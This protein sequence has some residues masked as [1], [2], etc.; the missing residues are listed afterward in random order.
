MH[1]V[2]EFT[3][4][5][6]FHVLALIEQLTTA[7]ASVANRSLSH[8]EFIVAAIVA[9]AVSVCLICFFWAMSE[10]TRRLSQRD[11]VRAASDRAQADILL[12]EAMIS[13]CPESIA[14]L[15]GARETSLSYR[16]GAV[17]LRACLAGPD[18]AML[19]A[20][21]EALVAT[22]AAFELRLRTASLPAVT[23]RGCPV[24]TRAAVFFRVEKDV[25]ETEADFCA[26]LDALPTPVW[27]RNRHLA[28]T[29]ANRAFLS[30][31]GASTMRDAQVTDTGLDRSE[32]DLARAASEGAEIV[33]TRRYAVID[34]RR[35]T[36][37]IDM[38]RL[39]DGGVA[40]F[41][42]DVTELATAEAKLHLHADAFGN[43][44]N[45]FETAIA[46]FGA[47]RRLAIYNAAYARMWRLPEQWLDTHPTL[48]DILDRLRETRRLPE[49]RDF[50][51]WKREHTAQFEKSAACVDETWHLPTGT[52]VEVRSFPYLLGGAIYLFRDISE[53]LRMEAS[54]HMLLRTQ[55]T[56]LNTISDAVA[57][58]GPD[59]RLK[60]HNNAFARF[61]KLD[62]GE[63]YG[64]PH[65]SKVADLCAARTG[66][67]G[68]WNIV[69]AG[70][71]STEPDRHGD[72]SRV[73]RAD[74]RTLTLTLNKLPEGATLVTFI[75]VTDLERFQTILLEE[76]EHSSVA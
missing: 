28:L 48:G 2:F 47:D 36:L 8:D 7:L 38:R 75:D 1:A 64:E 73:N 60:L 4:G 10:R 55:R 45:S 54:H 37:E 18:S 40:G 22:G 5:V 34:G 67:D 46:I 65:L 68:V 69:S 6:F 31:T 53:R 16:G 32:Y 41:A 43:V 57:V 72:W 39:P 12:R 66:R 74:G 11:E 17:L 27:I 71:N 30:L 29:W 50:A 58:F 14:V 19:A 21:L 59:G 15:D 52:S 63:L 33:S 42:A 51:D 49:R 23:A 24:G 9:S 62:E 44:L 13:A 56:M 26:A 76:E 3:T 70:V 35:R 61:W 20:K 25:R